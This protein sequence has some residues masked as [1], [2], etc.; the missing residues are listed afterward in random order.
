MLPQT[1]P[2][3]AL[4]PLVESDKEK[5]TKLLSLVVD[6][7]TLAD[8]GISKL[9]PGMLTLGMQGMQGTAIW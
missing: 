2:P 9:L 5:L 6:H 3:V 4:L 7:S 1:G 8:L